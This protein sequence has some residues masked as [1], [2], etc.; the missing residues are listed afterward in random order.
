MA[1][2]AASEALFSR[3]MVLRAFVLA[4][5]L[6]LAVP[7]GRA[8]EHG[9]PLMQNFPTRDYQEHN[10]TWAGVQDDD[11]VLYFGNRGCVLRYDGTRWSSLRVPNTSFVRGLA[12]G[13]DGRIYVGA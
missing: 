4:L 10:Q 3:S 13:A 7:A 2:R 6:S 1:L 5:L 12:R 11:G 9:L 8:G